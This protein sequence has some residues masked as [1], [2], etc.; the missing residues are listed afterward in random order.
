MTLFP[1]CFQCP[2]AP[3]NPVVNG[4]RQ[5]QRPVSGGIATEIRGPA[6]LSV[7]DAGA[8][9]GSGA[10]LQFHVTLSRAASG[11]VT[12]D[13]ATSDG[14]ATAGEDYTGASGMLRFAAGETSRTI[15]VAVLDDAHDEGQET[16][17][18]TL[19]NASNALIVHA[20]A[21]GTIQNTDPM[22]Q[23]WLAR[24][25]RASADHVVEAIAGRWRNGEPKTPQTHFTLGGPQV[26]GLDSLFDGSNTIGAANP[27]LT[28]ESA[29]ARMDRLKDL[30]GANPA[31]SPQTTDGFAVR[32]PP[33]GGSPAGGN[34]ADGNLADGNLAD[35]NL[36]DGN[37][38][39]GNLAGGNLAGGSPVGT[40]FAGR[41]PAGTALLNSLGLPTRDLRDVLMGSSFFYSRPLDE[42]GEA[43]EPPG[44]L[45]Q[46]SAWGQAAATRFSGADGPL[47]LNGE[48]A[49]AILG[50][51]SRRDRWLAGVTLS[52]SEGEGA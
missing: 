49:T 35:G 45:G 34:L 12:V 16:F 42:H 36:A 50:V 43:S 2:I 6:T 28:D 52:H 31:G 21:T 13:Y 4:Q 29:C 41:S 38:A 15:S 11:P 9:E 19:S 44:W 10:V 48:V 25:G 17:T 26:R 14:T 27:A 51:D 3:R 37:L 1:A 33:A 24:F 23:A 32:N 7:A 39:G 47:S 18:L 8:D 5:C 40:S 46:W 22:P 20:S 30:A